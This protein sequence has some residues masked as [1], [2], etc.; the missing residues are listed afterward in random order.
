MPHST[1]LYSSYFFI[2]SPNFGVD[3]GPNKTTEK[4]HNNKIFS[5]KKFVFFALV[6]MFMLFRVLF[7]SKSRN[8][9]VFQLLEEFFS[10]LLR[11][12]LGGLNWRKVNFSEMLYISKLFQQS[13]CNFWVVLSF[14]SSRSFIWFVK[15]FWFL[16]LFWFLN[17]N[18][19]QKFLIFDA[20]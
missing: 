2:F 4:R 1:I 19:F 16:E 20:M 10:F 5:H 18:F 13:S 3:S 7:W 15:L 11:R 9:N 8:K 6:F 14:I 17:N 12:L